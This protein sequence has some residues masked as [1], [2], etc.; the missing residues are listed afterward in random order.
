MDNNRVCF[1]R[2]NDGN[3]WVR[4]R[5]HHAQALNSFLNTPYNLN[6]PSPIQI[7][8]PHTDGGNFVAHFSRVNEANEYVLCYYVD[9]YG[10]RVEIMMCRPAYAAFINRVIVDH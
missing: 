6:N 1:I 8:V 4:S 5:F 7:S 9:E 10:Q 3:G 2:R